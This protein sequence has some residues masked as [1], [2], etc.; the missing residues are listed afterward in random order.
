MKAVRIGFLGV[1]TDRVAETTAFFRDVV[2]LASVATSETRTVTQ[3]PTGRWDFVEV[4]DR[5]FDDDRMIR[6]EIDGV[7]VAIVVDDIEEAR[8]DCLAAEVEILG[9]TIRADEAFGNPAYSGVAWFFARAPDG[10]V[11]V[12]QQA[13]D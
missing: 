13:P 9:E 3:L 6:E 5:D 1:R 2:G 4:F 8:R 7:F 10:N 11:Y 12:F